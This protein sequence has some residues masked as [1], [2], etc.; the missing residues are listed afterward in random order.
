MELLNISN[1]TKKI[2]KKTIVNDVSLKVN[3]GEI[4]GFLGPNGAGKTTTIKMIMGLFRITEGDITI[5]GHDIQTHFTD[6]MKNVGAII[7]NPDMYKNKTG[8]Q[9]LSYYAAMQEDVSETAVERVIELIKMTDRIDDKIKTYSLGM[10]QRV[11]LAQALMHQPKLIVLDEP[12]NGLDPIGI[13]EMRE[14]LVYLTQEEG[15]GVLV[16]SH[17]LAEM[18][19]MCTKIYVIDNGKMIGE[20][21]VISKESNDH[22]E[23]VIYMI[24]ASNNELAK[25]A[26]EKQAYQCQ[27]IENGLEITLKVE[28]TQAM[29]T[30]VNSAGVDINN[31]QQKRITLEDEFMTITT[32]TQGQIR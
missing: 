9:V 13:K 10:R 2:R 30:C 12:T 15:C 16:S 5:C 21:E 20:K 27:L 4:V 7:E 8:R 11:G 14:L 22:Q 26:L 24:H 23:Y 19:Q 29:I 25:Q 18:E 3:S 6:A 17:L 31:I 32:G 1:V 28:Q